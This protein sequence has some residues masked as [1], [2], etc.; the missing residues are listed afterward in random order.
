[1]LWMCLTLVPFAFFISFI[2]S[3]ALIRIGHR[4]GTFD[5]AGVAG[6]IK[7][8][9]RKVPNTGGVAI[10]LALL[11]PLITLVSLV[12]ILAPI[13]ENQSNN[14]DSGL[15]ASESLLIPEKLSDFV[16]GIAAQAPLAFLFI[17]SVLLLHILGLVDDRKPLGPFLKLG[18]MLV[19]A[20]GVPLITTLSPTLADTRLLTALDAY[21]GGAWLSIAITAIW[22]LVMINAMNFMDNMDGLSAG[23]GA[24][25]AL[26]LLAGALHNEQW[27]VAAMLALMVGGLIGFL[28]FN[29]PR[30]GGAK[31]F[32]GDGGSIV[33]GFTL[34]FLTTRLTY[35][36]LN[37]PEFG[38]ERMN[39]NAWWVP[40]V[41]LLVLAIP[42][43]DFTSVVLLRLRQ[44][45]SPFVGDLQHFSHR[46]V[47]LGLTRAR[48]VYV[49]W[50]FALVTGLAGVSVMATL[51]PWAA[52]TAWGST[53]S[54]L[55]VLALLEFSARSARTQQKQ[56]EKATS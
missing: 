41:P 1:M 38:L 24:I 49:I 16:P 44:R 11:I 47:E 52:A 18:V 5:S 36:P 23:V 28:M 45:K 42:L 27:F 17:A 8:A 4:L 31:I 12:V 9:R 19:P 21:V 43:Y 10:V 56:A 2:I 48:A 39:A 32:M 46:L 54:L 29:A 13:A 22:F 6:Q 3:G 35:V 51:S 25:A 53:T 7:A 20:I 55:C 26:C 15:S 33:V 50:G 34:A 14:G 37:L 40:L 30:P